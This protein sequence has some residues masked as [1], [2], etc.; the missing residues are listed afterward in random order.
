MFFLLIP[1]AWLLGLLQTCL[2]HAA[3]HVTGLLVFVVVFHE[4][5]LALA[6]SHLAQRA[7]YPVTIGFVS[8][9]LSLAAFVG[10]EDA[11]TELIVYVCLKCRCC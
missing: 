8:V 10:W 1:F 11:P 3:Y 6:A 4:R 7:G 5:L 9:R 2:L